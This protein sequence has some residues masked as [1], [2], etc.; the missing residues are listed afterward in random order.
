MAK[1][2]NF[3]RDLY[4]DQG[5]HVITYDSYCAKAAVEEELCCVKAALTSRE[6]AVLKTS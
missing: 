4:S 6:R 2:H 3:A 1:A 5:S